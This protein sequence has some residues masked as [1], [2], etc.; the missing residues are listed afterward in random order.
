MQSMFRIF[1]FLVLSIVAIAT[2]AKAEITCE[3]QPAGKIN[4]TWSSDTIEYDFNKSQSQ[5]TLS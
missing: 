1:T 4:I 5:M 2:S 3:P